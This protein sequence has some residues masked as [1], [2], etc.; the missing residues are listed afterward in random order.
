M[1]TST[2]RDAPG[3]TPPTR[4]G[5]GRRRGGPQRRSRASGARPPRSRAAPTGPVTLTGRGGVVVVF[6]TAVLCGLLSRW[7][8]M[9]LL[10]GGGFTVGCVLAA[11]AT[12]PADLLTL[13]V[14]PPLAFFLATLIAEFVTTLGQGS[15]LRGVAVG[16]LT[17]LAGTA[18]WLFFGTLLVL[19]IT[20]PRGLLTNVRELRD[21]LAGVR[22]FEEEENE[23]PVR[24]DDSPSSPARH[25][26]PHGDVD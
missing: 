3:D 16:V 20:L 25:A 13:A 2:A 21:K 4:R 19:L 18:P 5:T 14:S 11:L 22:L 8:D 7:L 1:S 15:L 6:G 24:W 9:P 23:N 10:A 12:R 17:A 26:P